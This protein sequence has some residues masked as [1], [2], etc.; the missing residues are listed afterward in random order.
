M[1]LLNTATFELE[2]RPQ[3]AIHPEAYAI[4]SHRWLGDQEIKFQ[5]LGNYT[6]ELRSGT[7]PLSLPQVDKIRGACDV[8][9]SKGLK[10]LWMDTCCIDKTDT[11]EYAE[12]INSMF[13]WY[14]NARVCI[15]YLSDVKIRGSNPTTGPEIFKSVNGNPA[16]Q[17]FSRGWTLQELLAPPELEFY[18]M[19]WNYMGT[20]RQLAGAL[21]EVTGIDAR[22]HTGERLLGEA[23]IA[24]K[25]SWM[26]RRQTTYPEDMA[27]SMI[28][29]F[30]INMPFVY[31]ESGPRAFRRLQEILLGS[32]FMDESLFAWKMPDPDAGKKCEVVM[33]DWESGEWGLLAGAPEWFKE[34]HDL[35]VTGNRA[36]QVRN[37]RMTPKGIEGPIRRK[38]HKGGD[39]IATET[40]SAIFWLSIVG[41][42]IGAIG[43]LA[44]RHMLNEKAKEIYAFRLNCFRLGADG[45]RANVEIHLRPVYVDHVSIFRGLGRRTGTN[46]LTP[47]VAPPYVECK[48]VR[49]DELGLSSKPITHYGD[50]VVFQP[51]PGY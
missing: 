44:L 45:Q 33:A 46:R 4:L 23:C 31:G 35:Q 48:R 24:V 9:R 32:P 16:S 13:G 43:F 28:G 42:P 3:G 2:N 49:C 1:R 39:I 8:A 10:W 7:R 38:V 11:R 36:S 37:F 12:A 5:E 6:T 29:I 14:R 25:M 20:K 51:Q 30:N 22:Y 19:D 26:S 40:V 15:T 50:G 47:R 21:A 18:D 34:S 17:W 27:Y 41:L